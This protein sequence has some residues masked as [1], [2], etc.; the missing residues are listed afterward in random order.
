M[1]RG[2]LRVVLLGLA[3]LGVAGCIFKGADADPYRCRAG[4]V[5]DD[6]FVC[7]DGICVAATP[8][9]GGG[10]AEPDGPAPDGP[11]PDGPVQTDAQQDAPKQQDAAPGCTFD[12]LTADAGTFTAVLVSSSWQFSSAGYAQTIADDLHTAWISAAGADSVS[13][14]AQVTLIAQGRAE[15]DEPAPGGNFASVAGV[16]VRASNLSGTSATGYFCG[17]D[18]RS[19]GRL[20]LGKMSGAY[21]PTH[22]SFTIL[23][24]QSMTV[25]LS[26]SYHV[27]AEAQGGTIRCTSGTTEVTGD[28]GSIATGSVGLFTIGARARFTDAMYCLP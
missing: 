1:R 3:A 17:V 22:G 15:F 18:V 23:G 19:G 11:G 24:E 20:L 4:N 14:Q 12:P 26:S 2:G 16:I 8:A 28:D 25:T 5:C 7:V 13:I 9:D 21:S 10:D 27:K 6:G